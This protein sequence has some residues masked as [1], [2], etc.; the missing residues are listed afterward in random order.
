M[1]KQ[2]SL[3]IAA[4]RKQAG[5]TLIEALVALVV[6]SV[7]MLALAQVQIQLRINAELSRQRAEAVRIAQEDMENWRA[8]SRLA[9]TV[10]KVAYADIA[11][12]TRSVYTGQSN[13]NTEFYLAREVTEVTTPGYKIMKVTVD[14][15]TRTGATESVVVD[16]LIGETDP[17]LAAQLAIPPSGTPIRNPLNRN[18]RI[19]AAAIDLGNNKSGITPP[20]AAGVFYVFSNTNAAVIERCNASITTA[21]DY[22]AAVQASQCNNLSGYLVSGFVNFDLRNNISATSPGSTVCDFYSDAASGNLL[23]ATT[24][25][26]DVASVILDRASFRTVATAAREYFVN[27]VTVNSASS[28]IV[29]GT[30]GVATNSDLVVTF[31][32]AINGANRLRFVTSGSVITLRVKNGATVETFTATA[33]DGSALRRSVDSNASASGVLSNGLAMTINPTSALTANTLYEL[34]IP[35]GM[36]KAYQQGGGSPPFDTNA[37]MTLTFTTGAAP[38]LLSSNPSDGGTLSSV[39]NNLTLT[40]DRNIAYGSGIV[41]LTRK[42]GG[43]SFT[44]VETFNMGSS[45]VGGGGGSATISGTTLI[46][47]PSADLLSGTEYS[48]LIQNGAIRDTNGINYAGFLNTDT[49]NFT[50][51]TTA[52]SGSCP[53]SATVKN[54]MNATFDNDP[55]VTPST[56]T[57]TNSAAGGPLTYSCYSDALTAATSSTTYT[58]GFFCAVY[59][60]TLNA[61]LAV[62]WSGNLYVLGPDGWLSGANSR[63]K[64]CRYTNSNGDGTTTMFEHPDPYTNVSESIT[65]QNFLV[66]ANNRSC[67]N[68]TVNVGSQTGVTVYFSTS[69]IQP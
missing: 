37:A 14:W 66:I 26:L 2:L 54:F 18:V 9:T 4:L 31:S 35:A 29:D 12:R 34:V 51:A 41:T 30:G 5:V 58:V 61:G 49:L 16:S 43:N 22:D 1:S 60:T 27:V 62:S 28:A 6:I 15:T 59:A 32:S 25:I 7:G 19:P 8:F 33:N 67:P 64:V 44:P 38:A 52:P 53:T 39:A 21:A 47:D 63:Y 69:Q 20:G 13:A 45:G 11:D 55:L 68:E 40:F 46:I 65:D 17:T 50:T 42:T 3:R 48:I 56:S 36:V 10:G 57:L 23:N 24:P